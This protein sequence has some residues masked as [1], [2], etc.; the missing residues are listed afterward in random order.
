M[1]KKDVLSISFKILG[2]VAFMY[3]IVLI[4]NIG[5]AVGWLLQPL[6]D[7]S[8]YYARFWRFTIA[9]VWLIGSLLMGIILLQWGDSLAKVLIK[10]DKVV[11]TKVPQDWGKSIY[12]LSLKIIGVVWLIKGIPELAKAIADILIGW[13]VYYFTV[14]HL[15]AAV[16][17]AVA[18]LII[19]F[20]LITNGRF[21][22]HLAFQE[23]I[24]TSEMKKPKRKLCK[25]C[26]K[27]LNVDV[28]V[29][30]HCG[31]ELSKDDVTYI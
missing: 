12:K 5:M 26:G 1:T 28:N 27:K 10:E 24:G 31:T 9:L 30:S 3:S 22:I 14:S 23:Q 25:H 21:F 29:C 15:F 18:S 17:G 4:P 8:L 7:I 20:Y 19:G 16:V 11:A 2:V 6:T 13:K